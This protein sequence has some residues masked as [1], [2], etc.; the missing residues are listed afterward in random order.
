[1]YKSGL[2]T[3]IILALL[4]ALPGFAQETTM[5]DVLAGKTIP[6]SLTLRQLNGSWRCFT[7]SPVS[8]AAEALVKMVSAQMMQHRL[9]PTTMYTRGQTLV[10]GGETYLIA[11]A[12]SPPLL[13]PPQPGQQG[14]A[15]PAPLTADS[16]MFL[17]LLNIRTIGNLLNIH[18]FDLKQEITADQ[19]MT[20]AEAEQQ[21]MSKLRQLA[22]ATL[23]YD[24]D[25]HGEYPAMDTAENWDAAVIRYVGNNKQMLTRPGMDELYQP[26][27]ALNKIMEANIKDPVNTVLAFEA[28]PWPDG[29]R[30]VAFADAHVQMVNEQ[31]WQA[32][33]VKLGNNAGLPAQAMTPADAKQKSL[34]NLRQLAFA[35]MMYAQNPQFPSMETAEQWDAALDNLDKQIMTRPSMTELYQPNDS[36]SKQTLAKIAVPAKTML[37]FEATPWP[38]ATRFVAFVDGHVEQVNEQQWQA[39]L[40]YTPN[41]SRN[42]KDATLIGNLR[43]LR[44]ALE[45]FNADCGAYPAGLMDLVANVNANPATGISEDG[46]T[47]PIVAGTYK[48]PYLDAPGRPQQHRHSGQPV[49]GYARGHAGPE[50]AGDALEIS[51][52]YGVHRRQHAGGNGVE[53]DS[54]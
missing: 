40:E 51:Q 16:E 6:L 43:E 28:T 15:P 2:M 34:N 7:P 31:Q 24:Q 22:T 12:P 5:T 42:A 47:V 49:C 32:L 8:D 38:D 21:S 1:M 13:T 41:Q 17:S 11:Y 9:T 39:L 44:I 18:P 26:N 27:P 4:S 20:T 46:K 48:G 36:L 29:M 53:R 33:K 19:Q 35:T 14:G 30:C 3:L 23:M 50:E 54:V 25:N 52:W 45:Q 37:A 10:I